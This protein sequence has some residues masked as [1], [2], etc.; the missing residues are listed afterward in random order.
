MVAEGRRHQHTEAHP[1]GDRGQPGQRGV[2]LGQVGPCRRRPAGSGGGDPSSRCGRRPAASA[3]AAIER[4]CAA[5]CSRPPGQSKLDRCSPTLTPG[6]CEASAPSR[7]R[8]MRGRRAQRRGNDDH[9]LGRQHL[10]PRLGAH[11]VA[12]RPASVGTG[13]RP[14]RPARRR[15]GRRCG[16]GTRR[17]RVEHHGDARHARLAGAAS[18]PGAHARRRARG[19]RSPSS[20]GVATCGRRSRRARR[21]HRRTPA[22][23]VRSRRPRRAA[24]RWR[25]SGSAA[26]CSA[27]HDDFPD[28]TGPISTTRHG[29]GIGEA[30]R[31]IGPGLLQARAGASLRQERVRDDRLRDEARRCSTGSRHRARCG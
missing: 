18:P 20:G 28:A 5:S 26:K 1:L 24:H 10:V 7:S 9:R 6:A 22:D 29:D 12:D 8:R 19:C 21:T 27:A 2:R 15:R 30:A 23:R 14:H 31:A 13:W 4:R 16:G 25:R 3:S 17:R 11:R